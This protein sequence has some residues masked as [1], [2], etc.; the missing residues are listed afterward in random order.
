MYDYFLGGAHNFA[1][2]REAAA[3]ILAVYP[4]ASTAAQANRSFL[5]RA[6]TDL[7][8]RGV[9]QFI[10]LGSGIPTAGN[11]HEIID[12]AGLEA[13]VVYVDNDPV[14][15][16]YSE[17]ILAGRDDVGV[18][19]ADVRHPGEVLGAGI[20]QKLIDLE[21]PVG[22]LAVAVLHFIADDEDPA[23][24]L[25][26]FREAV[27][28][29]SYLVLSHGTVDQQPGNAA[30]SE[31]IY[32]DTRDPLTLRTRQQIEALSSGWELIEPGLVWVPEWHPD[33]PD[34]TTEDP[35]K[36]EILCAIGRKA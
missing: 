20:T 34:E 12:A 11:V 1:V 27:P 36:T 31:E 22:V 21:Q 30:R 10:D 14:A 28:P 26:Q 13:R 35:S 25:A 8:Q 2:D 24:I 5:R 7:L 3:R 18:L 17:S 16:V 33:W 6:V 29:G 23:G 4:S 9:R 15:V 32:R 19:R